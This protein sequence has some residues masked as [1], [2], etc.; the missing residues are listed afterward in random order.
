MVIA[1]AAVAAVAAVIQ[2]PASLV[3][4]NWS[5]SLGATIII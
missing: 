1:M 5:L 4:N 3:K 2:A